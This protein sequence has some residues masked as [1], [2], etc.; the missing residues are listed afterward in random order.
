MTINTKVR[1][2]S[3]KDKLAFFA[4]IVGMFMAILDIQIVASSISIIGAGLSAGVDELSWIQT[5][6]IIAE[7]IIIPL[8]GFLAKLLSTRIAYFIA[9]LGFTIMSCFCAIATTI[10]SMIIARALQGLFGGA[11]IP[12]VFAT[13]FRIFPPSQR[14]FVTIIIGLVVTIAPTLGPTIGGYITEISSWHFMFL[15]NVIPGIFVCVSVFLYANFDDPDFSLLKNFDFLG[16]FLMVMTLGSLQY[17]LEEGTSKSWLED[18]LILSLTIIVV[19]GFIFLIFHELNTSKP[20]LDL[21]IFKN[22]DFSIGCF[23]AFIIGVGLYGAVYLMPLFL[24]RVA[25]LSSLQIGFVMFVTGAFQFLSAPVVGKLMASGVDRKKILA[26][27]F[28][29]FAMSCYSNSF[30]NQDSRFWELFTPQALRGFS[31]MFC[32]I[33]VNDIALG[34]VPKDT[35]QNASGLYNLMRNLGG[36]IGLAILNTYVTNYTKMFSQYLSSSIAATDPNVIYN[37]RH[38]THLLMGK[39]FN[40]YHSSLYFLNSMIQRDAFIIALNEI[41][42]A[43]ALLFVVSLIL[44]PFTNES[45][46]STIES[47]SH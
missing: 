31:L 10:E 11:M 17:I 40:P 35:V 19:L 22:K 12:T 14:P 41:F 18:N 26:I 24:Y 21:R 32:F 20:I 42:M 25:G 44:L 27:G 43:I 33:P 28:I 29:L 1:E 4:M 23:Y 30:L 13:T 6:Y 8:T 7:V 15:L 39:V 38:F 37:L 36:A 47:Q 9:T 2:L 16:V 34:S 5:A 46:S 3:V 45:I